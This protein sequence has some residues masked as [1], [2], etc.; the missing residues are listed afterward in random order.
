VR[1]SLGI[2]EIIGGDKFDVVAMQT[3][4]DYISSNAAKAVN[5]YFDCHM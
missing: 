1:K 4:A 3:S 2:G 5:T